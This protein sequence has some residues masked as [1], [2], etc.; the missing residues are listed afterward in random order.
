M[1]GA[2]VNTGAG[3][4]EYADAAA[5]GA[6]NGAAG[7]RV[8]GNGAFASQTVRLNNVKVWDTGEN[9]DLIV[10]AAYAPARVI[11]GT[12]LVVAPGLV[13]LHVHFRDPGQT[14]KE[15]MM[16]GAAAA[17]AGGFTDVCLQPNTVPTADGEP[18]HNDNPISR[19]L[20]KQGFISVLDYLELYEGA[21]EVE[22]PV[23]YTLT[24]AASKGR[25]GVETSRP[26]VWEPFL[27]GELAD[28]GHPIVAISDDGSAVTPEILDDVL[29]MAGEHGLFLM[30]HCEHHESGVVNAG[31]VAERLGVEGVPASTELAIVRRDIE[32]A[33]RSGVHVHLQHVST[34]EA[35]AAI[36][37]AKADGVPVTCETAPH[38]FAL[39]DTDV[40][41]YGA[42][43]KMNPP[44]RSESDRQATLAAIAD[45]TVDAIA[46]D[47]APHTTEEKSR[48]LLDSPNGIIGLETSYALGVTEL[49][50]SGLITHS[51]LIEL[52]STKPAAL[53]G[54]ERTDISELLQPPSQSG[55]EEYDGRSGHRILD[56]TAFPQVEANLSLL[57]PKQTWTVEASAFASKARN[58]PFDGWELTGKPVA[59]VV[60]SQLRHTAELFEKGT[61]WTD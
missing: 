9:V 19:R 40:E 52:M 11:D 18:L 24:V 12:G 4:G 56:L 22:L 25:G 60:N 47:H 27:R 53:I 17:A 46:T 7:D 58:T 8:A 50:E 42:M 6:G 2:D 3:A 37:E 57:A 20:L 55:S 39:R 26:Q 32:A 28:A 33:R 34:A 36:R 23:N 35:F 29:A 30:E 43:A 41:K 44:L 48:G 16:S 13:D 45:G 61:A 21:F 5:R 59:T 1:S 54:V 10:A 31:E 14:E 38:Y 49:V 51:R 15:D